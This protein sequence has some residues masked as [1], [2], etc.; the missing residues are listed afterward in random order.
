MPDDVDQIS[1]DEDPAKIIEVA[2]RGKKYVEFIHHAIDQ[3]AMRGMTEAEVVKTLGDPDE[4]KPS[5]VTGRQVAMRNHDAAN[6][7][8]VVFVEK[9]DRLR[10]ITVMWIK[11]R[12]SGR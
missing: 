6:K 12:L 5:S 7:A 8:R 1:H 11:R 4:I 10:V 3:M 2:I 9:A